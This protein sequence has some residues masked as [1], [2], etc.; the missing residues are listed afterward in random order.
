MLIQHFSQTNGDCFEIASGK[1]A[2]SREAFCEDQDVA[3]PVC[4]FR[5][6][7]AQEA[8]DVGERVLFG[9]AEHLARNLE[10]G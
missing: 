10:R 2:V 5:I 8:A 1:A 3:F 6:V 4:E 7:G 9:L